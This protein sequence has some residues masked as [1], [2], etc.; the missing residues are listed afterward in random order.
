[1]FPAPKSEQA[2]DE[3]GDNRWTQITGGVQKNRL[4]SRMG[5]MIA[6]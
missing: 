1:M 6:C 4:V 3:T 2:T 5:G